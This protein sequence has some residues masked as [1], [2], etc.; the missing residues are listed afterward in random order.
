MS[1]AR[2]V[3][4]SIDDH[5]LRTI[6]PEQSAALRDPAIFMVPH[7]SSRTLQ[8]ALDELFA[9]GTC[10]DF[11]YPGAG[12]CPSCGFIPSDFC[13]WNFLPWSEDSAPDRLFFSSSAV[14]HYAASG[15]PP[16]ASAT[17]TL[18][19]E[20]SLVSV[21]YLVWGGAH[22]VTQFRLQGK[23]FK[24]DCTRGGSTSTSPSFGS[25]WHSGRQVLYGYVKT[26]LVVVA[27]VGTVEPSEPSS[28]DSSGLS[29][30]FLRALANVG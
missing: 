27:G 5:S 2:N 26:D 23:W 30:A 16:N 19:V 1:W 10:L 13:F 28:N 18:G 29:A 22:Y 15:V 11:S 4:C 12:L 24:Y 20:Y 9:G 25:S 8:T 7:G 14:A 21:V 3:T 17:I 6:T